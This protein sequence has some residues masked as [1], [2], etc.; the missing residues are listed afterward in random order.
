[1]NQIKNYN[2]EIATYLLSKDFSMSAKGKEN[3]KVYDKADTEEEEKHSA[4]NYQEEKTEQTRLKEL[5][6]I[7]VARR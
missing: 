5:Q 6:K 2:S 7:V 4:T 1:M 3:D